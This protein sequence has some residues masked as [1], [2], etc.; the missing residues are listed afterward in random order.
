M[1]WLLTYSTDPEQVNGQADSDK[2]ARDEIGL[3]KQKGPGYTRG[4]HFSVSSVCGIAKK[5]KWPALA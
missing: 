3:G 5:A 1:F 4:K 2:T